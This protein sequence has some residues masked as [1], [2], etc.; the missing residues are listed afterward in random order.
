METPAGHKPIFSEVYGQRGQVDLIDY[1]SMCYNGLKYLLV[2]QDNFSK[3]VDCRPLPD[4]RKRTVARA[5][6]D[7]LTL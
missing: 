4:K 3:F 7:I 2:Y 6:L 5:L 1:Q